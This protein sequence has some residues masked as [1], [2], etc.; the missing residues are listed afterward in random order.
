VEQLLRDVRIA[1]IYEG[2]NGIQAL[3]LLGRKMGLQ[4]GQV[5]MNFIQEVRI[6][7]DRARAVPELD[8]L[9]ER[10]TEA[11][12]QLGATA[13]RLGQAAMGAPFQAA[14]AQATPFLEVMG[15]VIMAWMLLWRAVAARPGIEAHLADLTGED[16][17]RECA[18]N[19]QA[20]FY[21]GQV[22]AA[23]YFVHNLLPVALG[24]MAAI[25][26]LDDAVITMPDAGFGG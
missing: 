2:T 10:V 19:R 6:T 25:Q 16:R 7:I 5:F 22:H 15:D 8:T 1:S 21:E 3:D 17:Q 23:H 24:K 13:L 11:L 14:F 4:K 9:A 26:N 18:R 20:A 12:E